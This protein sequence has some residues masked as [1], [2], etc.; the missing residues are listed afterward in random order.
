MGFRNETIKKGFEYIIDKIDCGDADFE[1]DIDKE[2]PDVDDDV[3]NGNIII[4]SRIKTPDGTILESHH[5]HDYVSHI[6]DNGELYF[7]DGGNS[8]QRMN[9]NKVPAQN[10][11][12]YSNSPFDVIRQHLKRGTFDAEGNRVWRPL[13]E[14]SN[15]HLDNILTYD[16][17][18]GIDSWFDAY[19]R[20]EIKYRKENNIY[21]D[22]DWWI[23]NKNENN[24]E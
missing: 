16:A 13:C 18:R 23:K 17:D 3:D 20:K 19:V 11:S 6:D 15:N 1:D 5:T 7:L 2:V 21:I 8:Y 10:M 22:D 24:N 12:V 4:C 9:I 14:L